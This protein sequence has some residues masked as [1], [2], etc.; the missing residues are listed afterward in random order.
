M[1]AWG[2]NPVFDVHLVKGISNALTYLM[3]K[4][5]KKIYSSYGPLIRIHLCVGKQV[6]VA[7]PSL[8]DFSIS[9]IFL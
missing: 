1:C 3:Q 4:F 7:F 6:Q 8:P 2:I 9:L 5:H